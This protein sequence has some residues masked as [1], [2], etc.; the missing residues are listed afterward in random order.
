MYIQRNIESV[1]QQAIKQFPAVLISGSRQTGK[2]TLLQHLFP[3]YN[4]ITLDDPII[5]NLASI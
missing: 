3:H 1:L 5:R 4:Y 2:S